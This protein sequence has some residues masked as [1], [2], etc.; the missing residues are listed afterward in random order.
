MKNKIFFLAMALL[1][2][3]SLFLSSCKGDEPKTTKVYGTITLENADKWA[4]WQDSGVVEV[5]IFP[6]FSLDPPAGWG[7]IPDNFFGPGVPGGTFALGAPYNSQNP[8]VL[9]YKAG[10]TKYDYEIEV[11]P[12]TYS[13]LAIGFRNNSVTDP[14]LKTATLGCYW[15]NETTVSHGIVIKA[16]VGGG[17]IVTFFDYPAPATIEVKA[18]EQ[19]ELNFKADF[20]FVEQWYH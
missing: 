13:A 5:T 12:G 9:T 10:Q 20:A 3:S 6:A 8:V 17:N 16:D 15:D 4:T 18:N 19:K 14:S 7:A 11:E 2:V 1:A